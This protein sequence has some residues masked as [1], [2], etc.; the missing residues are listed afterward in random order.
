M[1]FKGDRIFSA[2]ATTLNSS[3]LLLAIEAVMRSRCSLKATSEAGKVAIETTLRR[4]CVTRCSLKTIRHAM[5]RRRLLHG[6]Y[7]VIGR[8]DPKP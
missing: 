4:D 1:M 5:P 3:S 7:G 2:G 8:L 6:A